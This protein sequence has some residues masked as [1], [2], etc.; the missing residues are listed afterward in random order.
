MIISS[1]IGKLVKG[2]Q[3]S[4]QN[5]IIQLLT[6]SSSCLQ[7]FYGDGKMVC[8]CSENKCDPLGKTIDPSLNQVIVYESNKAGLRFQSTIID[9]KL[10]QSCEH[11]SSLKSFTINVNIEKKYQ[12]IIGF[13]GAFTDSTGINILSLPEQLGNQIIRDYFSSEGLGYTVA[14]VPIGGS[15]FSTRP[16]TYDDNSPN[17]FELKH[18][19]MADED[20]NY[21]V[22]CFDKNFPHKQTIILIHLVMILTS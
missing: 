20:I 11:Q 19:R 17:D 16:Y 7:R 9:E 4:C 10:S 15:D 2:N 8:V 14:R 5:S 21:K 3:F 18:F 6:N 12:K 1:L 13:G 22:C